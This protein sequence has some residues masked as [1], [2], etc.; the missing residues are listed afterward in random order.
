V[1]RAAAWTIHSDID[2]SASAHIHAGW[3]GEPGLST[4]VP[5]ISLAASTRVLS[6]PRTRS[7]RRFASSRVA[8][9]PAAV[10]GHW[11]HIFSGISLVL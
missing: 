2:D 1:K 5:G 3:S 9:M 11:S 10:G 8:I 6:A 7:M 4:G